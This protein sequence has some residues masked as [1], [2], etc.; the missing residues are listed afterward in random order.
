MTRLVLINP[1]TS[2]RT[3]ETMRAIAQEAAPASFRVE[4]LTAPHGAPLI[5][6]A[7]ALAVA[8]TAVAELADRLLVHPPAGVIVSAFGDPGLAALRARLPCAVTGI[9]EAAMREA[10]DGGRAFAVVTTTPDLVASITATA[11]AYGHAQSFR[12]V[13]L[14]RGEVHMVMG[15]PQRLV[16]ALAEACA[17]A[18]EQLGA[19]ALVIGGGPLALAARALAD[20][21]AVPL[22]AP[23]PAAVRLALRRLPDASALN[24]LSG[25]PQA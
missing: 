18:I 20:R 12:G 21:F 8:A 24:E 7:P 10:A 16:E 15:D 23:I 1:N 25:R 6:D 22:I 3:T 2:S 17:E 5:T 19:Q 13:T 4:G 11:Q 9:A 14:T